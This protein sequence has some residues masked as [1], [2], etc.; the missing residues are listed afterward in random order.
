MGLLFTLVLLLAVGAWI[1]RGS[2]KRRL[3]K[4]LATLPA[5]SAATALAVSDFSEIDRH[6]ELRDC[7]CGGSQRAI[8]ERSERDGER[9]LRIVQAECFRCEERRAFYFDVTAVYH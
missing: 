9:M 8:G 1:A 3:E 6:I 4:V 2:R 5:G 7:R